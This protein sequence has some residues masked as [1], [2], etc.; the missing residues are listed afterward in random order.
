MEKLIYEIE[1]DLEGRLGIYYVLKQLFIRYLFCLSNNL[2]KTFYDENNLNAV[3]LKER[4]IYVN[5]Y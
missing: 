4:I 1:Y 2:I 3:D 5:V